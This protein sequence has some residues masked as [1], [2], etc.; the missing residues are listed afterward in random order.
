MKPGAWDLSLI[1]DAPV[2][3]KQH[4]DFGAVIYITPSHYGIA[5]ADFIRASA[6]YG[7]LLTN[8]AV[9]K[10]SFGGHGLLG[11]LASGKGQAAYI[12]QY[13]GL[14]AAPFTFAQIVGMASNPATVNGLGVGTA[15]SASGTTVAAFDATDSP[16]YKSVL[17]AVAAQTGNEYRV[18]PQ[19]LIDYGVP[20]LA[21]APARNADPSPGLFKIRQVLVSPDYEL[22]NT[23]GWWI[24]KPTDWSP[25][26]ST[27]DFRNSFVA[28]NNSETAVSN[29][30]ASGS[31]VTFL[32]LDGSGSAVFN[33][34][35][36]VTAPSDNATD[37]ANLRQAGANLYSTPQWSISCSIDVFCVPRLFIPGDSI[38]VYD[39]VEGLVGTGHLSIPGAQIAPYSLRVMAYS[40]PV[41]DGMGVYAVDAD[42]RDVAYDLTPYVEWETG[43]TSLT[44]GTG[45][46]S[47]IADPIRLQLIT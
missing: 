22:A 33:N 27:G 17:D 11:F 30:S 32:R 1:P 46:R 35:R 19:G 14:P 44:L 3:L 10:G 23:G 21:V 26:A 8:R 45:P 24:I 43:P 38:V 12:P 37:I 4:L 20:A 16:G 28:W 42:D 6:V 13:A 5:E 7:G 39:A 2:S 29:S 25:G 15:Y 40:W 18:T 31:P 47:P 34:D 9:R 41:Q 36:K